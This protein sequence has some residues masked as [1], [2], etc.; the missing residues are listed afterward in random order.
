MIFSSDPINTLENLTARNQTKSISVYLIVLLVLFLV[1]ALLPVIQL[2]ISSQS[3]GIV[4]STTDNVPVHTLVSGRITWMNLKNNKTI[5]QGDTLLK[6]AKEGL[7][8]EKKTQDTLSST[9]SLLLADVTNVLQG[10]NNLVKTTTVGQELYQYQAQKTELQSK[11]QQ[12]QNNYNRNKALFDKNVIARVEYEKY[13]YEL[14]F[15]HEALHSYESQQK[16]TWE[17]QKR[18]LIEKLKNLNGA[19]SKIKVEENNYVLLAPVTGTIENFSGLQVGSFITASQA[20]AT[21]S[22][23]D[24]LIVE[25]SVS[26]NDIGL[27]RKNQAVKFQIDAFNY[28]QWGLLQ[29][30][31]IDIDHNITLQENQAFFKV[32]CSL[33]TK[34]MQLKSGYTT[35]VTKGM[36][37]TT[38]YT[39]TRRSLFDLLFDKVDNWLNPKLINN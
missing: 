3:R 2:D 20:I 5:Q 12:A 15:A 31:V 9:V 22:P 36:T 6:I 7:L 1:L 17:N 11:V 18:E 10:K 38:R 25:S 37:L 14:R 23:L 33:N 4:R 26:P 8:V 16:A 13:V 30:K 34:T 29:G 19:V 39:I 24:N 32:R 35:Q 21:I 27:I 28:N